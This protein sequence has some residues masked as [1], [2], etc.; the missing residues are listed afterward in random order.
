MAI[1][2]KFSDLINADIDGEISAAEKLELQAYLDE[3]AE[4]RALYDELASLCT[5]LEGVE[6]EEPPTFMRHII[7][8][9]VP[10][11]RAKEE[12][13][14]SCKSCLPRLHL[15]TRQHSPPVWYWR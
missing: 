14:V 9:S 10:P 1:E 13:R 11:T 7:M 3:S 2:Q 6:Q 12:S 15:S 8:N 5:T 4:G